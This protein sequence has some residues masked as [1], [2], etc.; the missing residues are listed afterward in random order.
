ML[1]SVSCR[2]NHST[3]S[4]VS[5]DKPNFLVIIADDAGWNDLG[6]HGSEIKTPTLDSLA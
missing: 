2:E 3:K 6:F 1:V 5:T 4:E